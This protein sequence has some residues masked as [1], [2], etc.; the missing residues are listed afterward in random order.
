[1]EKI[2][3]IKFAR[4]F[5]RKHKKKDFMYTLD[6][7]LLAVSRLLLGQPS[8]KKIKHSDLKHFEICKT[9]LYHR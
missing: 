9:I 6:F 3:I 5:G 4:K 1:M 8:A 7:V 2:P